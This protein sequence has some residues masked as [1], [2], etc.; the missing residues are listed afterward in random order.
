MK[1][2][3]ILITAL[4]AIT[5]G[6]VAVVAYSILV[7]DKENQITARVEHPIGMVNLK[8]ENH[9]ADFTYAAEKSI[10]AVVH[11]KTQT[12]V[13]Y[14][15]PIYDFFY[16]DRYKGESEPVVGFGSGVIISP[17][18]YVVT[19]NHVVENSE[20]LYITLN[21]KR[22]FEAEIVGVDRSTDLA[23][24]KVKADNLH[25]I[26]FGS[27][28]QLKV[29]EWV[30][31]VGNP[32][33]ITSTVTAGIVS[34]KGR[35]MQIIQDNYRIES[36]IQT[37]A[38]VNRGN[39]GGALVN[40]K[41][42]LVGINTAI[43]SP[44]GGYVGISFAIPVS[45]VQKVVEDLIEFGVVQR[46]IIGVSISDVTAELAKKENLD[47]IEGVFVTHVHDRSAAEEA[48]IQTGDIILKINDIIV[49]SPAE[50]QEMVGRYSPG[51]KIRV[52]IKRK[53]KMKQF[54]VVLRNLQGDTKV[55][56]NGTFDTILGAKIVELDNDE[57]EKLGLKYGVKV[58]GLQDGKLKSEGVKEGFIITQVN[59]KP[60]YSVTELN[61]IIK[62]VKGGVYIEG[63]YPNGMVAYYAFGL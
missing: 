5:G 45:I 20:K 6:L 48:G 26:P 2:R 57:K 46:A 35:S 63:I 27:S 22:E 56:K 49:N 23:V 11:V 7:D 61:R 13:E 55:V 4:I 28:D 3:Q 44:S 25:Y 21:D 24:I 16:G 52:L 47:K 1:T 38:A 14:R 31:A 54:D 15:N 17:E 40:L 58:A 32:F 50:L 62:S 42:E 43:V 53:D 18:G 51:D 34:A 60:V 41:G 33:N 8:N 10:N 39:S 12:I 30:L 36:F 19:N 29:G 37:D 59:N 9:A